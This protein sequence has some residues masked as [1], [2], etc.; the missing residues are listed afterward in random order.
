MTKDEWKRKMETMFDVVK[1]FE[2][3][4]HHCKF[5]W[6]HNRQPTIFV[7]QFKST[8]VTVHPLF[9]VA[10]V[11]GLH[12]KRGPTII[13]SSVAI[14]IDKHHYGF[15]EWELYSGNIAALQ[16]FQGRKRCVEDCECHGVGRLF[17]GERVE[18]Q[19][20]GRR[21]TFPVICEGAV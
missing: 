14:L 10:R 19:D 21:T 8:T 1:S 12:L 13:N 15:P 4:T 6:C 7:F 9:A 5:T 17:Q 20:G 18:G 16:L 11:S 2:V 3:K